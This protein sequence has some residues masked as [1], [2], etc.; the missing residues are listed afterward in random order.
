MSYFSTKNL[1]STFFSAHQRTVMTWLL[2]FW[3]IYDLIFGLVLFSKLL[4]LLV[5]F[6]SCF[7]TNL[8]ANLWRDFGIHPPLRKPPFVYR[9]WYMKC[10][11]IV[12][13]NFHKF[14]CHW[15]VISREC[16][17]VFNCF[18]GYWWWDQPSH[19]FECKTK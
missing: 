3:L 8:L 7:L 5:L 19:F 4:L 17:N 14:Y 11:K 12:W 1:W 2:N 15:F 9:H 16:S 6:E 10:C 18:L 13:Q